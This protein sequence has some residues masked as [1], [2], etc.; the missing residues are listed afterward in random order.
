MKKKILTIVGARPQFIKVSPVSRYLKDYAD[1]ILIHTGQHYDFNMSD[2]FFEQLGIKKPDYNLEVGSGTHGY[3]TGEMLQGLEKI[4]LDEKP[5]G[6]L[7]YGD[8]NSTLAGA[9]AASKLNIPVFHVEAG[10]R[11]F[12][13]KMPEEINRVMTD[14]LSTLLFA[15]TNTAVRHLSSE[16]IIKG[17]HLVGDV[18]YDAVVQNVK[19]AEQNSDIIEAHHLVPNQYVLATIHRAENTDDKKRLVEIWEGLNL[20]H[21]PVVLPLHPRTRKK[22][23]D[24]GLKVTSEHLK[25]IDP[26]GYFD[27][28]TLEA[29]CLSVM[30]DSGGVQKEAYFLKKMCYTLR[31]ETEWVETVELGWNRLVPADREIIKTV[32]NKTQSPDIKSYKEVYGDGKAA[33]KICDLI[34]QA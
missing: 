18:M 28:L 31:T 27:M 16:G 26:V 9:L 12:N 5:D 30:T 10:L 25:L 23:E 8:T 24:M 4:M 6:I 15:P 7:V 14:H 11:S 19:V 33:Q 17:V 21:M 32:L 34:L 29:N 2:I 22:I 3:Q 13:R 1:E 20:I